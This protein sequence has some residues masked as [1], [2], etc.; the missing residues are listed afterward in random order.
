MTEPKRKLQFAR[1]DAA[2]A[3]ALTPPPWKLLI[4]DDEPEVHTVTRLALSD[5]R[6]DGRSL[7]F[8]SAHSGAQACEILAHD[9]EIA[10]M[11]LDVVMESDDAGLRVVQYTRRMLGNHFVRIILRTGHP[12][13][14][15]ER[16]I[17]KTYDI[18]DYR[19]KTELTQDRMHAIMY[20]SLRAY[21]RLT[22]MARN[23][24]ENAHLANEYRDTLLRVA[25]LLDA[26]AATLA[27]IGHQS[28]GG[29]DRISGVAKQL[30]QLARKLNALCDAPEREPV[31]GCFDSQQLVDGLQ[32]D[33]QTEL[34]AAGTSLAVHGRLPTLSGD[35]QQFSEVL[36]EL[37]NNA[38]KAQSQQGT[39]IELSAG[40]DGKAWLFRV[41][42]R[43]CGIG[44]DQAESIFQPLHGDEFGI[45]LA[46]CRRIVAQHGGRIWAE[47]REDGGSR[48]QFS[49]PAANQ[50]HV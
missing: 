47:P 1:D 40:N 50:G 15:P 43:G 3:G 4:V 32:E 13:I 23:R 36:K 7:E 14:A 18:N 35:R 2:T 38:L 22:K 9:P 16:R 45:G 34:A 42:D 29:R 20:T 19:A 33:L 48:I 21:Q 12:G 6:Y 37:I 39:D 8:I 5:F 17:I 30:E 27:E 26:P 49:W 24:R 10:V 46:K 28:E 11:L 25:Q 41:E 44:P 31:E